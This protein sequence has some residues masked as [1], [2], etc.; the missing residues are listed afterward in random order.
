MQILLCVVIASLFKLAMQG[1]TEKKAE[2]EEHLGNGLGDTAEEVQ[3]THLGS[4]EE[5]VPRE[6][7][8]QDDKAASSLDKQVSLDKKLREGVQEKKHR[9]AS[10]DAQLNEQRQVELAVEHFN[11]KA[12]AKKEKEKEKEKVAPKTGLF[13]GCFGAH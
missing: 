5:K 3:G 8:D 7:E 1:Q 6:E 12:E 11:K 13:C 2:P 4:G 10:L 9:T